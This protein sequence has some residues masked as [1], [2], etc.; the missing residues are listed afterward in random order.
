[1][2]PDGRAAKEASTLSEYLRIPLATEPAD[3]LAQQTAD[4][5]AR[6]PGWNGQT[7]NLDQSIL[8]VVSF[9]LATLLNVAGSV[10]DTIFRELLA[11]MF[12]ILPDDATFA[13][14]DSTWTMRDTAGYTI[15]AGTEV[16]V[17]TAGDTAVGFKVVSDVVVAPGFSVTATGGVQLRALEAGAAGTGL[18]GTASLVTPIVGPTVITLVGVSVA[19]QDAE[20]DAD[21]LDRGRDKLRDR[22]DALVLPDDVER[23]V[24][25]IDG[26]ERVLVMDN[27]VPG[28]N[29]LQT[30]TVT[31]ATGGTLPLT[32]SAQTVT[33][34]AYNAIAS[35]VQTALESLSNI[36]IGDVACTGGPLNTAPVTV[37]FKG[38]L[39][40]TNVA[41]MT[42]SSASLTGGGAAAAIATTRGGV[43][44]DASAAASLTVVPVDSTGQ[45]V[46]SG[47]R[48]AIL[49]ELAGRT[50]QGFLFSVTSPT[51]TSVSAVFAATAFPDFD[52]ATVLTNGI[53]ALTAYLSP[54]TWG[55]LPFGDQRSWRQDTTVRYWEAVTALNQAE[56]LDHV[57][58]L[59][60]NGGTADIV[61]TGV[62]PMPTPSTITGAVT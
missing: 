41:A 43:A 31:S 20:E 61:M 23:A 46:P 21:F 39:A 17:A 10:Q 56:G 27:Y 14:V 2:I 52:V 37:E 26:V 57:T 12:G 59:T 8:E 13:T 5:Q 36:D 28:V 11:S 48:D 16:K 40:G 55:L 33:G 60:L 3:V 53:A 51:Y 4:L 19:G 15:T 29:E 54:A 38:L 42:T 58:S 22:A 18:S 7:G 62:A 45:P 49:A 24:R 35:V 30:V 47:V 32:Y 44:A 25:R 6:V 9:T 50:Q 1:L 34:I